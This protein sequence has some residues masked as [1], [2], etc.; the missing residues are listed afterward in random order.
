MKFALLSSWSELPADS[1]RLF[2]LAESLNLFYTRPWLE[3][4]T[5]SLDDPTK[6]NLACVIKDNQLLALLPLIETA[7]NQYSSLKHRYTTHFSLLV[8]EDNKDEIIRCLADGFCQLPV[9]SLLLEP[10]SDQDE[11]INFLQTHL[12]ATGISVQV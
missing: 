12:I 11:N 9:Y 3:N 7:K 10:V 8:L 4:V 5:K 2:Q 1:T 6:L